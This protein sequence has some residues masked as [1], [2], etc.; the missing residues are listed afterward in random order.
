[1][2]QFSL[3]TLSRTGG[4]ERNEDACGYWTNERGS[5]FVVSDGAGGHKGGAIASEIAVRAILTAFASEPRFDIERLEEVLTDAERA[6]S[7]ARANHPDAPNMSATVTVLIIDSGQDY[8]LWG[9]IGDTRLYLF[10]R[11][12]AHRLTQDHSV[13]QSL[14]DAG[15]AHDI[16]TRKHPQRSVLYGALGMSGE[17]KPSVSE[18]VFA[19]EDG[20]AFLICSDGMWEPLV[21]ADMERT[22]ARAEGPEQWLVAMGH[23]VAAQASPHQDNY[24]GVAVWIGSPHDFTV[25]QLREDI[26]GQ[27]ADAAPR[28]ISE[29]G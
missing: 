26:R 27:L 4:R 2:M 17:A 1:M 7:E 3:G 6:I 18:T 20:D 9:H 11:G 16:D 10:R 5:C 21:E 29:Q 13:A 23:A 24:T 14:I 19:V 28:S 15:Y 25:T 22:L 12:R 8:A